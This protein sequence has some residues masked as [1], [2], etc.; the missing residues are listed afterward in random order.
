MQR[1]FRCDVQLT[2][3]YM[4]AAA[5]R[6]AGLLPVALPNSIVVCG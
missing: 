6:F 1:R 5:F 2:V 4:L 3:I